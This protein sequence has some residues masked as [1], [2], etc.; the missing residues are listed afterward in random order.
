MGAGHNVTALYEI[1]PAGVHDKFTNSVDPLKYQKEEKAATK[2]L[3]NDMLTIKF[4]YKEPNGSVSKMSQAVVI[5]KSV[6]FKNTS[7]DFRFATAVAEFGMLL[8]NSEFKQNARYDEAIK[9]AR[10]AKGDDH[11][12]YRAEFI[13]LA[14]SVKLLSK[15][16]LAAVED[17][18]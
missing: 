11:E 1:I 16:S 15:S 14:E 17:E 5:D 7:V 2:Y 18:N 3:S 12:G 9:I 10:A 4:R 8:R 13:K 6:D